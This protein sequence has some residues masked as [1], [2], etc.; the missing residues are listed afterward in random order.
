M[1]DYTDAD[2]ER[3]FRLYAK[4][5]SCPIIEKL[6][7]INEGTAAYWLRT[8]GRIR[9]KSQA[10]TLRYNHSSYPDARKRR[11]CIRRIVRL[12]QEPGAT[13]RSVGERVGMSKSTIEYYL[14]TDYAVRML[15]GNHHPR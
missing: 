2:K 8:S 9:T 11:R 7:G 15:H 1:S 5:L 4:G 14:G 12:Y 3:V 6:T 10:Q 13:Y